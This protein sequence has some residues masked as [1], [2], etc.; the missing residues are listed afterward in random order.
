MKKVIFLT[1]MLCLALA[2]VAMAENTLVFELPKFTEPPVLDGVRGA[3][4]WAG[5][6][7]LECSI[8]QILRDGAEHGWRNLEAQQ[9]EISV[10]QLVQGDDEDAALARTD[11]DASAMIW[12][13]WDDEAF[14]Y[15]TEV[16]DNA[17][18]VDSGPEAEP[19]HWWTRDSMSLYV[20]L[21]NTREEGTCCEGPYT[22]LNIINFIGAP[23]NSSS[24]SITWER[25][26]EGT[27]EPT[28]DP[29][30]LEGFEYGYR[31][32]EDEFGGE[33]DYVIEG[34]MPWEVLQRFNLP[35]QPTVGTQFG[36]SWILLD[37]DGNDG[38]G[39]QIQC[40][41]WA[42][43]PNDYSTMLFVETPAGPAAGTAVGDDS[44][45]RIKSTFAN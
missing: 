35:G 24:V 23:Q 22:S 21:S 40:W 4:E 15:I 1:A 36:F 18:D 37:P 14:Y 34:K 17:H 30:L 44:W 8:S 33:A 28:Q 25:T 13:A 9:S 27:R 29:D 32:A 20:D 42:D 11:D 38:Y 6:M 2:S 7:E 19:T 26:I 5:A 45:G 31:F 3:D 43:N 10:N 39:G 12:H 16:R 41:G